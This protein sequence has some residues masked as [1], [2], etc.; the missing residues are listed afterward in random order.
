MS[1]FRNLFRSFSKDKGD[2]I[3]SENQE[4]VV[5]TISAIIYS[6]SSLDDPEYSNSCTKHLEKAYT[7]Y[8][9]EIERLSIIHLNIVDCDTQS[10][11][12][13]NK[14]D[15][16]HNKFKEKAFSDLNIAL[17]KYIRLKNGQ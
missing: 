17:N 3:V 9:E 1:F 2:N 4:R 10:K 15:F 8:L 13:R 16:I 11:S 12:L 14:N 7:R 6:G 5:E